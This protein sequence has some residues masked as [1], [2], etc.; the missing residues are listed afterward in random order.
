MTLITWIEYTPP[1][2]QR[3][4]APRRF[5]CADVSLIIPVK[6]NQSGLERFLAALFRT[7]A[8]DALPREVIVV[9]NCSSPP[10]SIPALFGN[11]DIPVRLIRCSKPGP[12]S[13]RNAGCRAASGRWFLFADSDCEPTASF[14][15]GYGAAMNGSVGYAGYVAAIG[16]D[17]LSRYYV[18]QDILVPPRVAEDRPQYLITANSLVWR[19]AFSAVG[20][21]DESYPLAGGEDV[22]LGFR[23]SQ[24]GQLSYAPASVVRHDFGDGGFGF[25]RRFVRYGHGN[26]KLARDYRIDL[27]PKP[28]I[29]ARPGIFNYCAAVAQFLCLL[30]GYWTA[31][32]EARN[33]A[34]PI[35][36][37]SSKRRVRS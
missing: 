37:P 1:V 3:M 32:S 35:P 29:P 15:P 25:V 8:S 10:T 22:D 17:L 4:L 12:A 23:L 24:I 14:V 31:P 13:A 21:F 9:D 19:R 28:F 2:L 26:R 6:D 34:P 18:S 33:A 36:M 7:H 27:R 16:D 30:W 11:R 20:G 5:H